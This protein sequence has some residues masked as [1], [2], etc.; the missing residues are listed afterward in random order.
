MAEQALDTSATPTPSQPT[1][2]PNPIQT[3]HIETPNFSQNAIQHA[4]ADH[5]A[6]PH[7]HTTGTPNET[8][9]G[10]TSPTTTHSGTITISPIAHGPHQQI[11]Q[12]LIPSAFDTAHNPHPPF[13]GPAGAQSPL[14]PSSP[15]G[16]SYQT[17]PTSIP[18]LTTPNSSTSFQGTPSSAVQTPSSFFASSP[19]QTIPS[20]PPPTPSATASNWS[21]PQQSP[22][23]ATQQHQQLQQN[24]SP[25]AAPNSTNPAPAQQTQQTGTAP[26]KESPPLGQLLSPQTN[27]QSGSI[28]NHIQNVLAGMAT[29]P[30]TQGS[31]PTQLISQPAPTPNQGGLNGPPSVQIQPTSQSQTDR[32]PIIQ[33]SEGAPPS[34]APRDTQRSE[35]S[36]R[37]R[38]ATSNLEP[39][40]DALPQPQQA[41]PVQTPATNNTALESAIRAISSLPTQDPTPRSTP[42]LP[43]QPE[44]AA[45]REPTTQPTGDIR[46]EPT[47]PP[48]PPLAPDQRE[49][50]VSA[51]T[52]ALE[53]PPT[54][55]P[56]IDQVPQQSVTS[57]PS[58]S[59]AAA[60]DLRLEPLPSTVKPQQPATQP[61]PTH[62]IDVSIE[63][64]IVPPQSEVTLQPLPQ[65][66]EQ[67]AAG[68]NE[69]RQHEH[70]EQR[71]ERVRDIQ[72]ISATERE[73]VTSI[74][75]RIH[76]DTDI[77]KN[78]NREPAHIAVERVRESVLDSLTNIQGRL[79]TLMSERQRF[80]DLR[81]NTNTQF[82][83]RDTL[84]RPDP[85]N[86][87][88]QPSL[89]ARL[90]ERLHENQHHT[91]ATR[92]SLIGMTTTVVAERT[93]VGHIDP[94]VSLTNSSK[95]SIS[96]L[97]ERP[98]NKPERF[99]N[100]ID[101]LK[102]FSQRSVNFKLLNKM[103]TSLE[104]AC[105]TIATGAAVGIVGMGF[106]Y[107]SMNLAALHILGFLRDK[108]SRN[109]R[110]ANA[111][112]HLELQLEGDL[113]DFATTQL[114][115][116]GE[117]G[118]VVDLAGVVVRAD[119]ETPLPSIAVSCAEYGTLYTDS[120]GLFLF[121]NLPLGAP[122]TLTVSSPKKTFEPIVITG[123][124]GELEFLK[125]R[126]NLGK[127]IVLDV[128]PDK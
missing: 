90:A 121:P 8:V 97:Q 31:F 14:Q 96:T 88:A 124:C 101:L 109:G 115:T 116:V 67:Q 29:P 73:A 49:P 79:E 38:S 82:Q 12:M 126:V 78:P 15:P 3:A 60:P 125:I 95:R 23:Q 50:M 119:T 56:R 55:T 7:A 120:N 102:R 70:T 98:H 13:S 86:R 34:S 33:P 93:R 40:T 127:N 44:S 123:V 28:A 91:R 94:A 65:R 105:L 69:Q 77:R 17:Q 81:S 64:R 9:G 24:P 21:T 48:A 84:T 36:P 99:S 2:A 103:D 53:P 39:K 114:S 87:D 128:V 107:R 122:Y 100:L 72:Q 32:T 4:I 19:A 59:P 20:A 80:E 6:T 46:A 18:N 106:L 1:P 85:L 16:I 66:L 61:S 112:K 68:R 71:V 51:P 113:E 52:V 22:P 25:Q 37:E 110:E 26:V 108:E 35:Q 47:K 104:K 43:P 83:G 10:T 111:D 41:Q 27:L 92:E 117:Q 75:D 30:H 74:R 42:P 58:Q 76:A 118:F 63:P 62:K 89:I 45:P 11:I 57:P 5:A 54:A